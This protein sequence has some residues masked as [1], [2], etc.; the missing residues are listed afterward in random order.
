MVTNST[1]LEEDYFDHSLHNKL[2]GG[3][4]KCV[5]VRKILK[6]PRHGE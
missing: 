6:Q 3:K 1:V 4:T 2:E 5:S